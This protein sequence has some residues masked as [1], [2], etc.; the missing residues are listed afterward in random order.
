MDRFGDLSLS[1]IDKEVKG[2]VP[3]NTTKTK[4]SVWNQF[5]TFCHERT[6]SLNADTT[7]EQLANIL[8][9]W[10]YNM[11]KMDGGDYKEGVIKTM[12]NQ[13]AKLL[14][15]KYHDEFNIRINL[16]VDAVFKAARGSRDAKRKSLQAI[17]EKRKVS[18]VALSDQDWNSMIDG[19]DEETPEGLQKKI[20]HDRLG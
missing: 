2:N 3:I 11:K 15:E 6:Y 13:T 4:S 17:P 16:F 9:G 19:W 20:L 5:S 7:E 1:K 8:K 14:Q 18:A 10:G 12:C